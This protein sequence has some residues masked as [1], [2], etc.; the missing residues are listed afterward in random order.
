ME[1][2]IWCTDCKI[3]MITFGIQTTNMGYEY[4]CPDCSN[5]VALRNRA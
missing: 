4:C 2:E 3:R 1:I 5:K